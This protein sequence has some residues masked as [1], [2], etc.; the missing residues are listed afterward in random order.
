[1]NAGSPLATDIRVAS[2]STRFAQMRA[3]LERRFTGR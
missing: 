3:F 1:L 2:A